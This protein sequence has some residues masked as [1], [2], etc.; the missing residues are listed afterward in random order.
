MKKYLAAVFVL[1]M[2]LSSCEVEV[3]NNHRYY[4]PHGW[5]QRQHHAQG[6]EHHE[7]GHEHHEGDQEHH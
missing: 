2:F 6:P 3:R 7:G 4:H 1:V 5:G